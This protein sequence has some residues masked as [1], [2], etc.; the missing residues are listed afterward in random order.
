MR[1]ARMYT[2][3][4]GETHFE[5]VEVDL[6]PVPLV[7]GSAA[8]GVSAP[9][10]AS[11]SAFCRLPPGWDGAWHT[12]PRRGYSVI[13]SGELEIA[14]SDGEVRRFGPG[15]LVLGEDTTGKGHHD[16]V[17]SAGDVLILLVFFGLQ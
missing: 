10:P 1:Y 9:V 5:D 3:G 8:I 4:G 15:T 6:P 17:V 12:I 7:P 16:R 14:V 13:L 2:D 11:A